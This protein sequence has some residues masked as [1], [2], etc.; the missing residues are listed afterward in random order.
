MIDPEDIS[1]NPR[2]RSHTPLIGDLIEARLTR[3][4]LLGGLVSAAG[5]MVAGPSFANIG[6][7]AAFSFPEITR[8]SDSTHHVPQ[9]YIADI[10]L[11]WGDH[12]FD[13]SA[14]DFDPYAQ[15]ETD[16]LGRFGYNNDYIGFVPLDNDPT[17][18]LL[19]VNHEFTSTRLMFPSIA[20]GFPGSLTREH[21]LIEM[22]AQGGS[23]V[24]LRYERD[25]WVPV[26][27]SRFNRRITAHKTP[28]QITGPAAGHERLRTSVDPT[29]TMAAGTMN[30]CAGGITPW[31][32]WLMAEENFNLY[33]LGELPEDHPE[34]SSHLRYGLAS[35]RFAW[36]LFDDRF[37]VEK[38]PREP[39]RF[40]WVVEV[41]PHDPDSVPK[42]RTALGR[43]KHEGAETVIAP[44]GR[45]VIYMGDDQ[46]F[47]YVY[48]F[49]TKNPYRKE[50]PDP[51]L[52]DE[53]TLFVAKFGE[54][55]YVDWLPLRYG[56]GPL[57]AA[58]GFRSQADVLIET[59]R[60]AD[61]LNATPMDRPEDVQP[62]QQSGRVWVMLTNNTARRADQVNPANPRPKNENGHIIEIV[63]PGGDFAATRSRWE[64]LVQCGDPSDPSVQ[65][66]WNTATSDHG[67]FG[68][69][70][71]A[72][73]D[74]MGRLWV[75]TDGNQ[76]T[77]AADGIWA[78][79]TTGRQ[80]G[81]GKAFFRAPVGA[82]VCGPLFT[83]DGKTLFLAVQ[84]PGD[85]R[86]ATFE[87]PTTR[88]PD[89]DKRM[90]PRPSVLAVRQANG[91]PIG[92]G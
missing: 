43:F 62:D 92:E 88:W 78:I 16:Q 73:I 28:M 30:N 56:E 23:V 32:T 18:G 10:V 72:A 63:E 29:G 83:P 84:H 55:G 90:P 48:K 65:A 11:R 77:G 9:G 4:T 75:A 45:I 22:A 58:N 57:V 38:E 7:D 61:L 51:D 21:A 74:H 66:T 34:A 3:R 33:F 53:G 17:R 35:T 87:K 19:C 40:G 20:K 91:D 60:A 85:G 41:D 47:D 50:R 44:D 25:R 86:D 24:E 76:T 6:S 42:K 71:N 49:V 2:V 59:R 27:G 64:I 13:D 52:L 36:G 14:P 82:E 81:T 80:R 39:N 26:I 67:W 5:M 31:G 12:L 37:N 54:D 89:F 1:S 8:G 68:S 46:Q 69:P 15:S 70:D 79:E